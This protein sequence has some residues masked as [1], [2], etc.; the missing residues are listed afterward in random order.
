M[1][2]DRLDQQAFV[3][4]VVTELAVVEL[5]LDLDGIEAGPEK[6]RQAPRAEVGQVHGRADRQS[7]V[8]GVGRNPDTIEDPGFLQDR[9]HRRVIEEA[10]AD[11]EGGGGSARTH[12]PHHV[13]QQRSDLTLQRRGDPC[14]VH[15]ARGGR[16][17]VAHAC[18]PVRRHGNV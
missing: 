6:R 2:N 16:N 11:T 10:A 15:D 12:Q 18:R 9:V 13:D 8:T 5:R 14:L 4:P 17:R 3:Q 1:P 7:R